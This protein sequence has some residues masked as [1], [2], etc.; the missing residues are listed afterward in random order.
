MLVTSAGLEE[1]KAAV[2]LMQATA[3]ANERKYAEQHP[4][5]APVWLILG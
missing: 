3:G 4:R 2:S 1:T 5:M